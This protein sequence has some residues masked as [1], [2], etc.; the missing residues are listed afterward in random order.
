MSRAAVACPICH[1][2]LGWTRPPD[3]GKQ[4]IIRL[5]RG[6]QAE[7]DNEPGV[8]RIRCP[9]CSSDLRWLGDVAIQPLFATLPT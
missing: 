8:V 5:E 1:R 9:G 7:M 6:V 3:P 4:P 2:R